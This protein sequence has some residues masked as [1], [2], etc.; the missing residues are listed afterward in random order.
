MMKE[1]D[2]IYGLLDDI[3]D[4]LGKMDSEKRIAWF[5]SRDRRHGVC[6]Q[7]AL[8]CLCQGNHTG[9]DRPHFKTGRLN[10]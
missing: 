1:R 4:R 3:T 7:H 9:K 8:Q 5:Q 10:R 2:E 6:G